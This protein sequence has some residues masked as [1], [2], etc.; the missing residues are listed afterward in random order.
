MVPEG[1][2]ATGPLLR[3]GATGAAAAGSRIA[4]AA[5]SVPLADGGA[6][7]ISSG[8]PDDGE[9][10]ATLAALPGTPAGFT[11]CPGALAA[12]PGRLGI[13][14]PWPLPLLAAATGAET[15]L[16]LSAST[17]TATRIDPMSF[18]PAFRLMD[19]HGY[20]KKK[21]VSWALHVTP[22]SIF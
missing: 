22:V 5:G 6:G 2:A 17:S 3:G 8:P 9:P 16:A 4:G 11:L 21:A 12:W 14:R 19:H 13:D 15:T 18:L 1:V 10:G 7:T 20:M